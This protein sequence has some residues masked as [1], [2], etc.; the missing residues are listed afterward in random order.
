[1]VYS[2]GELANPVYFFDQHCLK[3]LGIEITELCDFLKKQENEY[4]LE[5]KIWDMSQGYI[6]EKFS[7][8]AYMAGYPKNFFSMH[9]LRSG[10]LVAALIRA[11]VID[12]AKSRSAFETTAI[13]AGWVRTTRYILLQKFSQTSTYNK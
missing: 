7:S 10:Y 6:Q 1:M 9:D 3:L 4:L 5:S 13:T 8:L 12:P 2:I 11:G